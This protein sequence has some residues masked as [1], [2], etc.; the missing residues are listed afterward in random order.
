MSARLQHQATSPHAT[1]GHA[2]V[3]PFTPSAFDRILKTMDGYF[4]KARDARKRL[5]DEPYDPKLLHAWRVNLRR[6][7]ATLKDVARFSDDDLHDVHAYLR[8]CREATGQC[9][10]ID[11]LAQE[12]LPSFLGKNQAGGQDDTVRIV[13]ERQQRAHA[14]ALVELRKYDLTVPLRAWRH[15]EAT[16]ES[17][18]KAMTRKLAATAI[19][20]RYSSLQ[21]RASKLDGGQKTLHRLRTAT[22]KLRYTIELY[23][24]AFSKQATTSWLKQLADLQE[25]LGLAHDRMMGRKLINALASS[26]DAKAPKPFRRWAKRTAYEA[27]EK[28]AQSLTRLEHLRHYWREHA[29]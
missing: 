15:W 29:N 4:A 25:H 27:S 22:K 12:T 23:A 5:L 13:A 2:M 3:K 7:T 16:L 10:D 11:I 8:E 14:Q 28:A 19:E 1:S 21:K 6:V 17:P 18:T 20:Q 24:P 9:R 26:N